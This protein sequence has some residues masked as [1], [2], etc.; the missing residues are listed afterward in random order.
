M[1]ALTVERLTEGLLEQTDGL[2]RTSE[3]ADPETW[4]PTCPDWV[5][6]VLVEHVGQAV[7]WAAALVERGASEP[8]L[9]TPPGSLDLEPHQWPDWLR[10]G[11]DRMVAAVQGRPGE[12]WSFLGPQ[13]SAFW[14]RRMLHETAVHHADAALALGAGYEYAPDLAADGVSEAMDMMT[15]AAALGLSTRLAALR[16]SGETL[17]FRPDEDGLEGWLVTR[18]PETI[19]WTRGRGA[20]DVVVTGRTADLLLLLSRRIPA[21]ASPIEIQ[22]D[23]ALLDHWLEHTAFEGVKA[24]RVP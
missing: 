22:G 11:A 1:G 5:L 6:R 24:E 15:K 23:R 12:V 9:P 13:P 16:G 4:I 8:S 20:T 10:G 7:H 3:G 21:D 2:A 19:R 17:G 14:L 18:M